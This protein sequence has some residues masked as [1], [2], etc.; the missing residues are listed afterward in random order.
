VP[1]SLVASSGLIIVPFLHSDY[2]GLFERNSIAIM[3][4]WYVVLGVRLITISRGCDLCSQESP[5][6]PSS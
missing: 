6:L 2:K 5:R 1:L 4:Q 3:L